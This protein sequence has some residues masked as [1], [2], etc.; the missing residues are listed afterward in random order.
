MGNDVLSAG[1]F[2]MILGS[3]YKFFKDLVVAYFR[4]VQSWFYVSI[5]VQEGDQLYGWLSGMTPLCWT[6]QP[7]VYFIFFRSHPSTHPLSL[8]SR[9]DLR[10][11]SYKINT[12]SARLYSLAG[13]RGSSGLL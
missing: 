3:S 4:E 2:L 8:S 12:P 9:L 6:D 10:A 13:G 11:P 5:V 7:Q 1:F